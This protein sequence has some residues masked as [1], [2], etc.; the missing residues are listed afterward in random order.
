MGKRERF[1]KIYANLPINL[2]EEVVV[3]IQDQ[4]ISWRVAYLEVFNNT[5]LGLKILNKLD[6]LMII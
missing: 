6:E 4:P 3:M 5:K 1:L 2:R